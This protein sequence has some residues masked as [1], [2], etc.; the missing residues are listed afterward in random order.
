MS[1]KPDLGQKSF[2]DTQTLCAELLPKEN[3]YRVFSDQ[4]FEVLKDEDFEE[5]Y[6]RLG[7]GALSPRR[8]SYVMLFQYL[9]KLSDRDAAE[10]VRIRLDW[11][12]ALHLAVD[13]PGFDSSTL[14]HFRDRLRECQKEQLVFDRVVEELRKRGYLPAGTPE[15][16]DS[17]AILAAVRDINRYQCLVEALRLVVRE[18]A[19]D[20]LK[21]EV[22]AGLERL[23][24][25]YDRKR[26]R[27][28]LGDEEVRK[29]LKEAVQDAHQWLGEV[30]GKQSE[31]L[32]HPQVKILKQ[33]YEQN[34]VKKQDP[35]PGGPPGS[36]PAESVEL[37]KKQ[38]GDR[39]VN[40]HDPE[41]KMGHTGRGSFLGTKMHVSETVVPAGGVSFVTQVVTVPGNTPDVTVTAQ[42]AGETKPEKLYADQGYA[43]TQNYKACEEMGVNLVAPP[44]EDPNPGVKTDEFRLQ[45]LP[46]RLICPEGK[47]SLKT[48]RTWDLERP[49]VIGEFG[50]QCYGCAR[51]IECAG[52]L[53]KTRKVTVGADHELLRAKRAEVRTEAW[54]EDYKKR[55]PVEGSLSELVRAHGARRSRYRGLARV[56]LRDLFLGAMLNVKRW[57]KAIVTGWRPQVAPALQ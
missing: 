19:Q 26:V 16:V 46:L 23:G 54:K 13:D 31:L 38:A 14:T 25:K 45:D 36:A 49:A 37:L 33:V 56:R 51:Q 50:S 57:V 20:E 55:S 53:D 52:G 30:E 7:R 4:L 9:E 27:Y 11:K 8:L 15:R 3:F 1:L 10:A 42:V 47:E 41:M 43:S 32:A 44:P 39:I 28:D 18:L 34:V 24:P 48:H 5:M 29:S 35:P 21:P 17:L 12:L 40:P 22:K 2:F 6:S